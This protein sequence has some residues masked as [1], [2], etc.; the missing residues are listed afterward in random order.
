VLRRWVSRN[1]DG[2]YSL[3]L[4]EDL[5]GLLAALSDQLDPLLDDPSAD[6]GLRRL[7]PPAHP[8]DL[9]AEAEW[10]IVQGG[11]LRDSRR[12]ALDALRSVAPDARLDEDELITWLQGLNALRLVLAERLEVADDPHQEEAAVRAAE[13]VLDDPSAS[14]EAMAEARR[15]L[16]TWQVYDLLATL[17]SH[18][19][20]AL[21]HR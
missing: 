8:D 4:D 20:T 19:V 9:I 14:D 12:G 10:Q 7:F 11:P 13:R 15:R 3:R 6:T 2:S 5:A 18:A 21:D 16:A 17:I 1:R